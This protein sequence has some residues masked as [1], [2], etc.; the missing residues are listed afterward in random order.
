MA[1]AVAMMAALASPMA[2]SADQAVLAGFTAS[3]DSQ[4]ISLV[5]Q[6]PAGEKKKGMGSLS[7]TN[8]NYG[9]SRVA[10]DLTAPDRMT[11]LRNDLAMALGAQLEGKPIVV[12]H[13]GLYVNNAVGLRGLVYKPYTGAIPGVMEGIGAS[14][15]PEKMDGGWYGPE[16]LTTPY[17]PVIAE[18]AVEVDGKP[19]AVR[20]VVSPDQAFRMK[21]KDPVYAALLFDAMRKVAGS[22]AAALKPAE[23]SATP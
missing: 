12:K 16:E 4:R 14:C 1:F 7:I 8:C 23:G 15:P 17:S 11:L 9:V 19:Y 22:L 10:D 21:P 2:R 5:D 20:A 18:L 13:Y 6:R 3:A